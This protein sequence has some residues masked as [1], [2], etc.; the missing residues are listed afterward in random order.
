MSPYSSPSLPFLQTIYVVKISSKIK[1]RLSRGLADIEVME[2]SAVPF[3][4]LFSNL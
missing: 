2:I 3:H 1:V 4:G